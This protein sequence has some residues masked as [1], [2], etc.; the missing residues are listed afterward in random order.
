MTELVVAAECQLDSNSE[1]LDGADGDA[2]DCAADTQVDQWILLAVL[3][4][5]PVNHECREGY[6]E[7]SVEQKACCLVRW[8]S[9]ASSS[10]MRK[11]TWSN[12]I[13]QNLINRMELFVG[14][15]MQNND[16]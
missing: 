10:P 8:G 12:G 5:D 4:S 7:D 15:R 9:F 1:S 3:R 16:H 11:R 13:M 2:A 6:N 14:R